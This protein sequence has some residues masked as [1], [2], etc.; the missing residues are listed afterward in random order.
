MVIELSRRLGSI[1]H[2]IKCTNLAVNAVILVRPCR[3]SPFVFENVGRT[4]NSSRLTL[5][6]YGM[7]RNDTTSENNLLPFREKISA[8][9]LR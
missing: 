6:F 3:S 8:E 7:D 9:G 1:G 4:V 2:R 5:S